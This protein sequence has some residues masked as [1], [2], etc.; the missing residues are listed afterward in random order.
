MVRSTTIAVLLV[1][2]LYRV[3]SL[4]LLRFATLH[5]QSCLL[6]ELFDAWLEIASFLKLTAGVVLSAYIAMLGLH[7]SSHEAP[8]RAANSS[9]Y[10]SAQPL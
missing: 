3:L 10:W 4:H 9:L 6:Y 2:L 8:L 5:L 7:S 1:M